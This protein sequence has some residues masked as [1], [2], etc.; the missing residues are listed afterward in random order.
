MNENL[1]DI[2]IS[3]EIWETRYRYV[4]DGLALDKSLQASWHRV[5]GA[6]AA[7]E[8]QDRELWRE[9]FFSVLND[10]HFLPGGRIL[11]GA[12]TDFDVTLFNCFVMGHIEDS[13][14]GIFG[15][16]KEAAVTMQQGGGVGFD[17]STLRPAGTVAHRVGSMASGPVSFMRIWD[18]MCAT[19]IS[20]ASR[21]GAMMA[22]LR[23]DHP[24][25]ETFIDAKRDPHE[26][27]NFNLSILVSDEFMQALANDDPWP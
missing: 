9:R 23:C 2:D 22:T 6:L 1:F 10:F 26:L 18:S 19:L 8:D 13:M 15:G 3:R 27:R 7:V 21:R 17:F 16:L 12:G 4:R 20:S 25:I 11:A 14:E 5:A 24:D